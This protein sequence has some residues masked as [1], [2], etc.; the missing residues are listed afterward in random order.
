M[1]HNESHQNGGAPNEPRNPQVIRVIGVPMDLG[2]QRRGVDM[3]P[4]AVRYAGLQARMERLGYT[5]YDCGNIDVP[6]VEEVAEREASDEE[7]NARHLGAIVHVCQSLYR[8]TKECVGRDDIVIFLGGD[9]SMS[10]GSVAGVAA[11]SPVGVLWIDAHADYNTPTSS[12]SG[13]VHGMPMATLLGE[14]PRALTDIGTPGAKLHAS[15][16]AMIGIR[17]LDMLERRRLAGSGISVFTMTEIDEHGIAAVTRRALDRLNHQ[18]AIHVSLDMDSLD[19]DVAPGVGT[20]VRGG[21]SYREA[22]LL[23][24]ILAESGKVR[25][26]DIVE[27]NPILDARNQTAELAVDLAASLFGQRIL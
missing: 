15:Q 26:M 23:M 5:V 2:Q 19:P 17:N 8:E 13:N 16:V 3:G 25:S 11:R 24:E 20:P 18:R 12:P 4:S 7:S 1:A 27:I 10:V 14:G 22:H 21:L 9:H 6:V